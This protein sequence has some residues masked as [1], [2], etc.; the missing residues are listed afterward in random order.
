MFTPEEKELLKRIVVST[1]VQGTLQTLPRMLGLL[2]SIMEK[3]EYE[4]E[5]PPTLVGV[6]GPNP[7]NS[8]S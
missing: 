7:G 8:P 3:L 1:P 2:M 4:N 5:A 6:P